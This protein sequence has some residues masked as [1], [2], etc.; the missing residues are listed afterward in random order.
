ME[1]M[2]S[3]SDDCLACL[4]LRMALRMRASSSVRGRDDGDA[5]DDADDTDNGDDSKGETEVEV[6]VGCNAGCDDV[7]A[8]VTL[9]DA[10]AAAIDGWMV[11][12][13]SVGDKESTAD[14]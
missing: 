2:P 5:A 3:L 4:L 1:N 11:D 9:D 14:L 12:D 10:A 8:I 7:L 13:D 6:A